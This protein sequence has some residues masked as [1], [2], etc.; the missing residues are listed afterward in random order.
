M[1]R[2]RLTPEELRTRKLA[3]LARWKREHPDRYKASK[4]TSDKKYHETNREHLLA[5]MRERYEARMA[6]MTPEELDEHR[7]KKNVS[8]RRFYRAHTEE[9]SAKKT[10]P[11][12][13]KREAEQSR[14][15]RAANPEQRRAYEREYYASHQEKEVARQLAWAKAH[16]EQVNARVAKRQARIRQA[17]INDVTPEQRQTVLDAARGVCVYCTFYNPACKQCPKGT[18]KLTIDHITAIA[19]RG[20]NTLHNLDSL[21]PLVQLQ[22]TTQPRTLY[23]FNP[24]A[25]TPLE[26]RQ[27]RRLRPPRLILCLAH[28]VTVRRLHHTSSSSH[29]APS[30]RAGVGL[31]V[32]CRSSTPPLA[33]QWSAGWRR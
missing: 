5:Q 28:L 15:R 22:E 11:T 25:L 30:A 24:S 12:T 9:I 4:K 14:A 23:Q 10:S 7:A 32:P 18:H 17:A 21:L 26:I 20:D 31:A 1:P 29:R 19:R 13:R 2:P 8:M 27:A 16:P 3:R 33:S 6:A